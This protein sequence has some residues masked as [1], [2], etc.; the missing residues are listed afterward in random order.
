M[1]LISKNRVR[2]ERHLRSAADAI[3]RACD[4]LN[5]PDHC[6]QEDAY[7]L[8]QLLVAEE[9][10]R[11]ARDRM[12]DLQRALAEQDDNALREDAVAHADEQLGERS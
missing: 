12:L 9:S 10:I 11:M 6:V 8:Q 1:S 2:M 3:R 7:F 4:G 5:V